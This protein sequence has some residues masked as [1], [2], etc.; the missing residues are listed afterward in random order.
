MATVV[1]PITALNGGANGTVQGTDVYAAVDINDVT[2]AAAGTTKRYQIYQMLEYFL[3]STGLYVY[4][5]CVTCSVT[6]LNA[7]YA[8]G[9]SGAGATLTNAGTQAGFTL[10]DITGVLNDR[11]LIKDQTVQSQNG[12]YVLTT[13]GSASSN[14]VL[15]RAS[16]FNSSSNIVNNGVVF[17]KSGT[18]NAGTTWQL[19]FTG[20]CVVGTT[21]FD[22]SIFNLSPDLFFTWNVVTGTTQQIEHASG[23]IVKNVAQT[24]LQLPLTSHVGDKFEI[25]GFPGSGGFKVAQNAGQ[26][27]YVGNQVTSTGVTGYIETVSVTNSLVATCIDAN[28]IWSI[29]SMGNFTVV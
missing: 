14:W 8:N 26:T 29:A 4:P 13:V 27:I 15:T 5:A 19:S 11:F 9:I 22:F 10:N 24:T 20:V 3:A 25:Y 21:L 2:Q 7:V 17:V 23:Y 16:D 12:I 6:N 18:V 28:D 1:I